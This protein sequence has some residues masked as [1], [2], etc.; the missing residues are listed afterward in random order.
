MN[1]KIPVGCAASIVKTQE[2]DTAPDTT[3]E[4]QPE[5]TGEKNMIRIGSKAPDFETS[6][7]HKGDFTK[8]KLSDH[9]GKWIVLC[10]YPGDFTFVCA[11]EV[12]AVAE[13]H[14]EFEK[15]G[16]QVLSVST[17]SMFVHKVWVDQELGKMTSCKTV[18][19]PML[20]DP[21][22]K[23]GELY[24]VYSAEEGVDV[25]G[26]FL[27]DPD[28]IIQGFEV[29]TPPVGRNVLETLRHYISRKDLFRTEMACIRNGY[30]HGI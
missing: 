24:G 6:A 14:A 28:G 22:G 20:S 2:N 17:D 5:T 1:Q 7:Y 10:F 21:G 26:R 8:V 18:P 4:K 29:L 30:T 27:I 15:L 19:F 11:T 9:L 13:K 3:V 16:T 25:R 23:I 12:S